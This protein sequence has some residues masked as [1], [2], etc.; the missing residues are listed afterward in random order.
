ML[1][2]VTERLSSVFGSRK[3]GTRL[4]IDVSHN[5]SELQKTGNF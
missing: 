1:K 5:R 3:I 4:D 2:P